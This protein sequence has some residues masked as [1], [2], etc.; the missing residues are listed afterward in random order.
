MSM[1]NNVSGLSQQP[2]AT[3]VATSGLRHMDPD[4]DFKVRRI[5]SY[6]NEA[7]HMAANEPTLGLYRIQEHVHRT[8][9]NLATKGKSLKAN[10]KRIDETA[11]DLNLSIEVVDSMKNIT[12]FTRVHEALKT[13][14]EMKRKL[15]EQEEA[16]KEQR[17]AEFKHAKLANRSISC[18]EPA[19]GY[20]CPVC[21]FA[22][23]SQEELIQHWQLEHNLDDC[24]SDPFHEVEMPVEEHVE[25]LTLEDD[26][27][28]MTV[29]HSPNK[30]T[31]CISEGEDVVQTYE[32]CSNDNDRIADEN[33]SQC[34]IYSNSPTSNMADDGSSLQILE[35][36]DCCP[37]EYAG[38]DDGSCG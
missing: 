25:E 24:E 34:N 12:N 8:A 17:D 6:V 27:N 30:P 1:A 26:I 11:Y 5:T 16:A 7:V 33:E 20:I 13:A 15:N 35:P 28:D 9:P 31:R 19:E 36:E 18:N 38:R 3:S 21:Y 22:H 2:S 23:I 10:N 32:Q 37:D 4:T 14:I 29:I